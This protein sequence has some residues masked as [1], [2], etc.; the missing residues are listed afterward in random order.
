MSYLITKF[1][2]FGCLHLLQVRMDFLMFDDC[3][4]RSRAMIREMLERLKNT[5]T[6]VIITEAQAPE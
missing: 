6:I 4:Q 3:H 2:E 1:N 5:R